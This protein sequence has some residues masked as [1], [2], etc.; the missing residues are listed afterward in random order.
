MKLK[1][2]KMKDAPPFEPH[3]LRLQK[4]PLPGA[5][6]SLVVTKLTEPLPS[7]AGAANDANA[8]S[9]LSSSGAYGLTHAEW[10]NAFMSGGYGSEAMF[11]RILKRLKQSSKVD[12]VGQGQGARYRMRDPSGVSMSPGCQTGVMVPAEPVSF[13]PSSRGRHDTD[14]GQPLATISINAV[15][16]RV[17]DASENS[18]VDAIAGDARSPDNI[19][20]GAATT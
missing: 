11:A 2:D 19:E 10:K 4:V 3:N 6:E 1:C 17:V 12:Q 16:E 13:A 20:F 14:T 15:T 9:I 5:G 7:A 18:V 8:L